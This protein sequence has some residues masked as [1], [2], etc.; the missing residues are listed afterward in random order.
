[1]S[2]TIGMVVSDIRAGTPRVNETAAEHA[3][4]RR[5]SRR[6]HS[7]RH[8]ASHSAGV[9]R[10]VHRFWTVRVADRILVLMQNPISRTA[11]YTLG[12]RAWDASQP[13]PMCGDSFAASFMNAEAESIWERFKDFHRPNA[14]NAARHNIIDEHLSTE[15]AATPKARV[16]VL[17]AG[18]D[19]RAFRLKGGQWIEV[20]EPA[21]ITYKEARLP[22]ASAPN[23]LTRVSIDFSHE[24]LADRLAGYSGQEPTHV[25]IEGVLMYLTQAQRRELLESLRNLFPH[26]FV[27]CDLMRQSFFGR[28]GRDLHHQIVALG[29]SFTDLSETPERLF[30]DAGYRP[31]AC[32]SIALHAAELGGFGIPPFVIRWFLGT[33]RR[34]YCIW[35][36]GP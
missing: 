20:D 16:V 19:T 26:H 9:S 18:F 8:C 27:Y 29:A 7:F 3:V 35:K 34:G 2:L 24:S 30:I 25:V 14:C 23:P 6:S 15:L 22:A 10:L 36:F 11:Y 33:L 13:K 28:Y 21:I 4:Y 12:V 1:M 32:T 17:G 31:L 5:S